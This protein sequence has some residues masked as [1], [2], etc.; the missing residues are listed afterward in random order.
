MFRCRLW[1]ARPPEGK[2]QKGARSLWPAVA[3]LLLAGCTRVEIEDHSL[4]FNHATG[5]LGNRLMLLNI[6][7]A[8][9]GYP[10]QFSK[11]TSYSGQ[12][13]VDGGLNLNIP[14]VGAIVGNPNTAFSGGVTPNASL[15]TGVSQLQLADLSTAE[16]Q[17]TLRKKVTVNDFAYYR[18]QGWPSALVHT[19]LIEDI[20]VEP[21]LREKLIKA[22]IAT[23]DRSGS[24]RTE[25]KRKTD[26][27][28][29]LCDWLLSKRELFEREREERASPEGDIVYAYRNDPRIPRQYES[30]QWFF[31]AIRV[32]PAVSL[33]FDLKA[34]V[35]ECTTTTALLRDLAKKAKGKSKDDSEARGG[36][37]GSTETVKEGKVAVDV[38]VK[39][40]EKA[41]K[42]DDASDKSKDGGSIGLNFPKGI[43]SL[44]S[45]TL[46]EMRHLESLRN[47]SLCLLKEGRTPIIINWRS[48]ERM[49][50]YLGEVL[51]AQDFGSAPMRRVKIL[52]NDGQH[53]EL[54][55]IERGRD[56]VGRAAAVSVE[57]PEGD[58]FYIPIADRV[59]DRASKGAHLSLRALALVMESVNLAVSGKE[60]PR[61]TTLFLSGG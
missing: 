7:R 41:D 34:P 20:F 19:L 44:R 49:V 58:S 10:V 42:E 15:K 24:A 2:A 30:F 28:E 40:G 4:Q 32:L 48:P 43:R 36:G 11:V 1:K 12:S 29:R 5:S 18:S 21:R 3:F 60:L 51:A 35:D 17:R 23:C 26:E 8:A 16:F 47:E 52:N 46:A 56:E 54:L 25:G 22:A 57:G 55:R 6:V 33:D 59:P 9:K 27:N 53:V 14:F 31:A 37:K 38:T 39:I 50:R 45:A 13:R 61:T